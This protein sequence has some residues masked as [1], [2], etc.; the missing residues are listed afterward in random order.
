MVSYTVSHPP[1]PIALQASAL[2]M[3]PCLLSLGLSPPLCLS[4][5]SLQ[6]FKAQLKCHILKAV[7]EGETGEG[8]RETGTEGRNQVERRGLCLNSKVE[9]VLRTGSALLSNC[10]HYIIIG[11]RSDI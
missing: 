5:P 4:S 3:P 9:H 6:S 8:E 7:W 2:P 10:Y 11:I 1:P